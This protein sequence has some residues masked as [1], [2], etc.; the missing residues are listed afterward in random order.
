MENE[1]SGSSS[2][3]TGDGS[4]DLNYDSGSRGDHGGE[5]QKTRSP[6]YK[7]YIRDKDDY[8]DLNKSSLRVHGPPVR[9]NSSYKTNTM[10][11]S[12]NND[13]NEDAITSSR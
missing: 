2:A 4:R 12:G 1:I 6:M 7:M 13:G 3:G 9:T 10:V 5:I 11:T 8:D